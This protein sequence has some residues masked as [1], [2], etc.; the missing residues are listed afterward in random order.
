MARI[1]K[2]N[3]LVRGTAGT[4]LTG[5]HPVKKDAGGSI[6]YSGSADAIG[7]VCLPG[8]IAAGHAV[9]VL[10]KGEITEY[11]GSAG[12]D[13]YALGGGSI[14]TAVGGTKVG[15]T[16]EADRLIVDM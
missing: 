6:V 4:V 1:D 12:A 9:G 10:K 2:S 7:V 15:F 8:T 14:G 13:Y 16:L 5:L 11:G 3:F